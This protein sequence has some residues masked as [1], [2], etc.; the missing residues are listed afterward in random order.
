M[1][2][3]E[4]F[5]ELKLVLR[6]ISMRDRFSLASSRE[7]SKFEY[8]KY[9]RCRMKSDGYELMGGIRCTSITYL[10]TPNSIYRWVKQ[11]GNLRANYLLKLAT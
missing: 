7:C 10:Q 9:W 5:T 6:D 1:R 4:R 2:R 3:E 8:L 11:W